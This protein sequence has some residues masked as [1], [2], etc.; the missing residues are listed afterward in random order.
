MG[1]EASVAAKS[2]T[3]RPAGREQSEEALQQP[4]L[5]GRPAGS[6]GKLSSVSD[7]SGKDTESTTADFAEIGETSDI[8]SVCFEEAAPPD[9]LPQVLLPP[10]AVIAERMNMK[11]FKTEAMRL[12]QLHAGKQAIIDEQFINDTR[13]PARPARKPLTTEETVVVQADAA[14]VDDAEDVCWRAPCCRG[15]LD[16]RQVDSERV[17]L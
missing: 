6:L 12:Q 14:T 1:C 13:A 11:T 7:S 3:M 2:P 17:R 15:L 10:A 16:D 4:S 9:Q 5:A 8:E